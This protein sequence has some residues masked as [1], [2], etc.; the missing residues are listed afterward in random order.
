MFLIAIPWIASALTTTAAAAATT[1]ATA[2]TVT[3]AEAFAAGTI[4]G[5]AAAK[6][7]DSCKEK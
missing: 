5:S 7:I 4:V 2:T 6:G 1:A 3:V